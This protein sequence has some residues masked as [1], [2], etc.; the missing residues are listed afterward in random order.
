MKTKPFRTVTFGSL[1]LLGLVPVSN[2]QTSGWVQ[3]MLYA[4]SPLA[5]A[6][7]GEATDTAKECEA[8]NRSMRRALVEHGTRT[9]GDALDEKNITLR[10]VPIEIY[11]RAVADAQAKAAWN[12]AHPNSP[13]Q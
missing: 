5:S 1:L 3:L 6:T 7:L 2:A 10:C 9:M 8:D 4:H 12:A 11:Y 13:I